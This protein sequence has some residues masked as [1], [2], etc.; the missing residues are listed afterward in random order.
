VG[1][2]PPVPRA[3]PSKMESWYLECLRVW[4]RKQ[5]RAPWVHELAAWCRKS[6]TAVYSALVSL[7]HKGY[8]R[9]VG[10]DPTVKANRRFEVVS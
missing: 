1:T 10:E 9:R 8:V 3:V 2:P 5:K 4:T 6:Q 7:E